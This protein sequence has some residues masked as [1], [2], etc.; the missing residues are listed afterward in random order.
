MALASGKAQDIVQEWNLRTGQA[1]RNVDE[2]YRSIRKEQTAEKK[3][4]VIRAELDRQTNTIAKSF[5]RMNQS[6]TSSLSSMTSGMTASFTKGQLLTSGIMAL[7]SSLAQS[8][9][10]SAKFAN[11]QAIFTG[12]IEKARIATREQ[13]SDLDLMIAKNRLATLGVEMTDEKYVEML[14][15]LTKLASAMSIDMGFALESATTMLARQSTAVAD[16]IGVIIKAEE[17]YEKFALSQGKTANQ[18]TISEKKL[19]FQTEALRQ[20]H[21][22]ASELPPTLDNVATEARGMATAWNNFTTEIAAAIT[23]SSTL[24]D[25]LKMMASGIRILVKDVG[26]LSTAIANMATGMSKGER[27]ARGMGEL[28]GADAAIRKK[29]EEGAPEFRGGISMVGGEEGLLPGLGALGTPTILG[30]SEE[31]K[32]TY[33]RKKKEKKDRTKKPKTAL[34]IFESMTDVNPGEIREI[35][36]EL[37][38]EIDQLEARR[39]EIMSGP[40]PMSQ[41]ANEIFA[42][43]ESQRQ[44]IEWNMQL[45]HVAVT[46]GEKIKNAFLQASIGPNQFRDSA[47]GAQDAFVQMSEIGDQALVNFAGSLWSAASQAIETGESFSGIALKMLKSITLGLASDLTARGVAAI[48]TG[49][50]LAINPFTAAAAPFFFAQGKMFL[51]GAALV[52]GMGLLATAATK[53]SGSTGA[54]ASAGS[55]VGSNQQSSI[56][57]TGQQT[58]FSQEKEIEKGPQYIQVYIGDPGSPTAFLIARKQIDEQTNKVTQA[59]FSEI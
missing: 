28:L 58:K 7:G 17:A 15:D 55:S 44:A 39:A 36:A 24:A 10:D 23:N 6:V 32:G 4:T 9:K 40:S 19:A 56:K 53:S 42:M 38:S 50:A 34:D 2:L 48:I 13:A 8:A 59:K 51:A 52:G 3:L 26:D 11:A 45:G 27:Q 30:T 20:M 43:G 49:N 25:T 18:L 41:A 37:L 35:S 57:M 33:Y 21:E 31:G 16:N 46:Q 12:N 22:K 5:Q 1:V 54:V 14:G 29:L 47:Q